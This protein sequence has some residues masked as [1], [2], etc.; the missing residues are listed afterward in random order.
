MIVFL[1]APVLLASGVGVVALFLL[2]KRLGVEIKTLL[3]S[4]LRHVLGWGL[5]ISV[6]LLAVTVLT[7]VV[8]QRQSPLLPF[9]P[10]VFAAGQIVGL[11]R[12]QN[13]HKAR[14]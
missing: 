1:I 3:P 11:M 13:K 10:W 6:P 4:F 14:T 8:M 7:T 2:R 12:F 5:F 9:A